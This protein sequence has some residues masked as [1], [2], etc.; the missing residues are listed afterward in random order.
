MP[1]KLHI[2]ASRPSNDGITADRV[3]KWCYYDIGVIGLGGV[4]CGI[5]VGDQV[6]RSLDAERM[7][8]VLNPK[9]EKVPTGVNTACHIVS[10]GVGVMLITAAWDLVPP[11]VATRASL[12]RSNSSGAT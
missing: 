3:W 4:D 10:L 11:K 12:K 6:T 1:I 7:I 2:D 8:G 5:K 9:T